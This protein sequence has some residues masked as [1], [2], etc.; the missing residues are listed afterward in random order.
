M[1]TFLETDRMELRQ[2]TPDDASLLVE[3][4]SDSRVMRYITGGTPTSRAEIERE[5]L[6]AF[7]GYYLDYPGYGF[8]AATEKS[9]GEFLG[10]FHFRPASGDPRDQPE[11]GYR[12]RFAAW[13][14]GYATEGSVALIAKGFAELGVRRVVASTLAV[15]TSSR[16]VM[17]KASIR[18]V[19]TFVADWPES[20]PGDQHCEVECA[21]T[22]P[23]WEADAARR[24]HE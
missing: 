10:W 9:T 24:G 14:K 12:L 21:I 20:S 8:W 22:R 6:P 2:F 3:L 5:F 19:R 17:E 13:G 18:L 11:L 16:R 23:E 4:D 15:N 1:S 7:L